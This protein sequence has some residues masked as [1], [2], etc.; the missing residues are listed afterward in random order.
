MTE[1]K[2]TKLDAPTLLVTCP[3]GWE[4]EAR[5]ELRGLLPGARRVRSLFIGGNIIAELA[6]DLHNALDAIA[7]AETY[8][9]AHVTPVCLRAQIGR[10]RDRLDALAEFAAELGPADPDLRFKVDVNRRGRHDFS[11]EEVAH[12]V[13]DTFVSG[14]KPAVDLVHPEQVASVQIFQDLCYLGLNRGEDLLVKE[15]RRMR[16]WAPG[17]R[18]ISR[19]ELKLREALEEFSLEPAPNARALDL[20]AA[21]GGW[22]R[23]LAE[24]VAEVVAVDTADL[25]ERVLALPNVRHLRCRAEELATDQIGQFDLMTNDMNMNPID[26][27][28]LMCALAPLLRPRGHAIMTIKFTTRKRSRHIDEARAVLKRCYEGIEVSRMPHNALETTAVMR[29]R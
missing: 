12:A 29:R 21:P 1:G 24:Q 15:L 20:G 2:P 4:A 26:S 11:S 27:A 18:P 22:T 8:T 25:H 14:G 19:A 3:R 13:A 7:G 10:T 28:E 9:I 5:Q 16:L 23:V 17:E 6:D